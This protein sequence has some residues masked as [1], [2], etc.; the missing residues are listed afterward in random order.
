MTSEVASAGRRNVDFSLETP[1]SLSLYLYNIFRI[2]Y[3]DDIG[4]GIRGTDL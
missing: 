1:D 3:V 4:T 2:V